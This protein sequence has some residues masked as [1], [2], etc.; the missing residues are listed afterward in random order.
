MRRCH[1][2]VKLDELNLVWWGGGL[3]EQPEEMVFQLK[4][5]RY[6]VAHRVSLQ[7]GQDHTPGI[8]ALRLPITSWTKGI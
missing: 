4:W 5:V 2:G 8:T 3:G 7:T 6:M 1:E